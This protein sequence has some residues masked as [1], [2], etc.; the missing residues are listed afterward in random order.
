MEPTRLGLLAGGGRFPI[1]FAEAARAAGHSVYAL[2]VAGMASEQL[3]DVCDDFRFYPLARIGKAIRLFKK[4][5][6]QRIVMAGKIEKTVLFHPF[7]WL[8]LMP[9][10]RTVHM[11]L[12]YARQNRKDDTIL[13]AIIREFE[14]DGFQFDSALDYAPEL[15]VKH[16]FLTHR[17]PSASQ[18]KDIQFGFEMAREMGRLDIG[19]TVVVNDSAV[20]A[21]EA[22]EGTDRCI[23]R[24]GELCRRGGFTVVKVAKPQQGRRFDVPTIGVETIKTMS[25]SGGRVLAIEADQTI[26]LEPDVVAEA[27]DKFGIAIVAVNAEELNLRA[28]A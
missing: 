8:R 7:R 1:E 24:A 21:V 3:G 22:I 15:L 12:R 4:A 10:L 2:G 16:G 13:L 25:E 5:G 26:I 19:Q 28:A 20:I 23:R 17:K 14:R 6:V 11:W 9:D 27:A 18:W